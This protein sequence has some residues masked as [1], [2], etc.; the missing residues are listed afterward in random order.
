MQAALDAFVEHGFHG[1]SMRD[2]ARRAG[3]AVSHSY[4][5]FASKGELLRTLMVRVTEDLLRELDHAA[6]SADPVDRLAALVRAHVL[7]HTER[8]AE[9]FVGNSELRSLAPDERT[10]IVALRDRVSDHFKTAIDDGIQQDRFTAARRD[11]AVL[12][13]ATM[14]TAVAGWY[15]ADGSRTPHEIADAYAALILNMLRPE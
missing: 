7:F 6:T 10:A 15:R 12:A 9:S 8:Q 13:V 11:E 1:T 4:Y 14:C 2:I 5:Y 3:T